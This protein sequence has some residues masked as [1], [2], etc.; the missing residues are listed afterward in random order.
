MLG[1]VDILALDNVSKQNKQWPNIHKGSI[2][3][4]GQVGNAMC[5]IASYSQEFYVVSP[6]L[7]LGDLKQ[8]ELEAWATPVE[9][10]VAQM[11]WSR[12][13]RDSGQ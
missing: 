6:R 11:A 9:I 13:K 3:E 1:P 12:S 8:V 5:L 2:M 10:Y 4:Y 7:V